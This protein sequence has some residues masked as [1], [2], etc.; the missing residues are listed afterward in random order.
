[1]S[2]NTQAK[3]S[4]MT[5]KEID[6]PAVLKHECSIRFIHANWTIEST[7]D[8]LADKFAICQIIMN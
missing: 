8:T 2:A 7:M 1:M 4:S 3:E 6:F 5:I